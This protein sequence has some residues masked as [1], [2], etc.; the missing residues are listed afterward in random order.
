MISNA[1]KVIALMSC[2][3]ALTSI[4][5]GGSNTPSEPLEFSSPEYEIEDL[6]AE[7]YPEGS[8]IIVS[9]KVRNNSSIIVRGYVIVY[10]LNENN[11]TVYAAEAEVNR[12][13]PLVQGKAG[14]F[15]VG[16]RTCPQ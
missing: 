8:V 15:E 7:L 2:V 11:E 12:N 3:V 13:L 4:A 1:V 6:T 14:D 16:F 5:L 9:G 10:F